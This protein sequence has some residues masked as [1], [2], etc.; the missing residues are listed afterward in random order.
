MSYKGMGVP[1]VYM[2]T[3]MIVCYIAMLTQNHGYF[4]HSSY[5][6]HNL[7]YPQGSPQREE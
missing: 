4:V 2:S 5:E 3:Y 1:Y 6:M 7:T